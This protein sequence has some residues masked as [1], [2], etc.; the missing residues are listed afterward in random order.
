MKKSRLLTPIPYD[1][2][3]IG[4]V[5]GIK[6]HQL[7]WNL[8]RTDIFDFRKEE[9][10]IIEFKDKSRIAIGNF[11]C[12]SEYHTHYLLKNKLHFTNHKTLKHMLPELQ[13]FDFFL[14]LQSQLD[15]FDF[16]ALI[17]S[18]RELPVIDYLVKLDTDN[19]KQK[20][21]LLF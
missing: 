12:S 14:K 13:Q 3:L 7:A 2:K 9:D 20:E 19:I 4:I 17:S 15:D 8:N 1:F 16:E 10:I 5:T 21:N 6:D 18:I 11:K